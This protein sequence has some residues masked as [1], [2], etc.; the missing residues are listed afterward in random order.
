[1]G[2]LADVA[3][4]N[5][6]IVLRKAGLNREVIRAFFHSICQF[7]RFFVKG[8]FRIGSHIPKKNNRIE[9]HVLVP[10]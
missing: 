8:I 2:Q 10:G 6:N 7:Y 1:M 5:K 4:K 9:H 3:D